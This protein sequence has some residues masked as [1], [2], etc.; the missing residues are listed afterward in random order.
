MWAGSHALDVSIWSYFKALK[1]YV[2][3]LARPEGSIAQG[4]QVDEALGFATEYMANY[5]TTES[6]VWDG[7][8]DATMTDDMVEE[9]GRPRRLSKDLQKEVH[10]FVLDRVVYRDEMTVTWL[11]DG[12]WRDGPSCHDTIGPA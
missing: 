3:N 1:G 7:D 9:K 12:S 8:E 5:T 10:D 11:C 6:R 4:Y 2:K